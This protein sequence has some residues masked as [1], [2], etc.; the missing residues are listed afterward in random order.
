MFKYTFYGK[1]YI[2]SVLGGSLFRHTSTD[3]CMLHHKHLME[4]CQRSR[5]TLLI[6]LQYIIKPVIMHVWQVW[7]YHLACGREHSKQAGSGVGWGWGQG[8]YMSMCLRKGVVNYLWVQKMSPQD[9]LNH[10][11]RCYWFHCCRSDGIN[12]LV[13]LITAK[14]WYWT[15][16]S[17][18]KASYHWLGKTV[19][20]PMF[21]K[22]LL[23]MVE[24]PTCWYLRVHTW[25]RP[26]KLDCL[27][28]IRDRWC[29]GPT[30][31]RSQQHLQV[32]GERGGATAGWPPTH[33][34]A[35]RAKADSSC[36]RGRRPAI[37][38]FSPAMFY[39][40]TSYFSHYGSARCF[41]GVCCRLY[42]LM[43][44]LSRHMSAMSSLCC[45]RPTSRP[46]EYRACSLA[47]ILMKLRVTLY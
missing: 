33:G 6:E 8:V 47:V 14:A 23:N 12:Q 44:A 39:Y 19:M 15:K 34:E 36:A 31:R 1:L 13:N 10:Q 28:V 7:I 35:V 4:A 25:S 18:K 29:A 24:V 42:D 38:S 21:C 17:F 43:G 45:I 26:I 16:M 41:A 11:Q 3:T 27:A 40:F 2:L 30:P 32:S 22:S 37:I 46:S 20:Q 5:G 9:P